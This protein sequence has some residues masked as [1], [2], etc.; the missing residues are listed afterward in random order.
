VAIADLRQTGTLDLITTNRGTDNVSVLL[1]DGHGGFGTAT[2][3]GLNG[4]GYPVS[5]AVAD[6]NED[7]HLDLVVAD[8]SPTGVSVLLGDG[9]GGF[10]TATTY[11][12]NGGEFPR[13]VGVARLRQSGL[14]Q[15]TANGV[16][17]DISVLLS[18]GNGG[19]GTATNYSL[20]GATYPRSVAIADLKG[21]GTL[22]VVTA[23]G[24]SSV[25]VLLG[26]G[27]GTLGTATTYS[28]NAAASPSSVAIADVNGDG[29]P[30]LVT[31]NTGTNDVSVLLGD[32]KGGF[33]SATDYSL[34]GSAGPLA[35]ALADVNRDGI[36]DIVTANS[37]TDDVSV[38]LGD[39]K[40]GFGTA[41]SYGL[42]GAS[43][44]NGLA[45]AD[46]NGDG[47]PDVV[48]ANFSDNV[49]VLLNTTPS[50]KR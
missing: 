26:N 19:Y 13:S 50:S 39:G 47:M 35:V 28:L 48:T 23:N 2:N 34:N 17:N 6:V 22:D 1:G 36:L 32:G 5:V 40:G 33:G 44:P 30:D 9:K 24:D 45:I 10:G 49:S 14:D 42:N 37:L 11:S 4:G 41:T 15:V 29:I 12:L 21:N 18:D 46:L 16:S 7:G 20:N 8:A 3:Y 38:L 43:T 25:S 27:D 31:A